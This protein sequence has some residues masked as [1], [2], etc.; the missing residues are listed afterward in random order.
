MLASFLL[1]ILSKSI[2]S[3]LYTSKKE[4]GRILEYGI[5]QLSWLNDQ[6]IRMKVFGQLKINWYQIMHIGKFTAQIY[7]CIRKAN[8]WERK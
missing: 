1:F 8:M 5:I 6:E 2:V 4:K 3:I 7:G